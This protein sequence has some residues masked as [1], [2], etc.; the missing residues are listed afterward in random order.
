MPDES[1]RRTRYFNVRYNPSVIGRS[2]GSFL[3]WLATLVAVAVIGVGASPVR[4]QGRGEVGGAETGAGEIDITAGSF[5]V[6]GICR[7]GEWIGLQVITSDRAPAPRQVLIQVRVPDIDGDTAVYQRSVASN[8]GV[9]QGAWIYFR[10]PMSFGSGDAVRV[11]VNEAEDSASGFRAGRLLGQ[12]VVQARNVLKPYEGLIGIIGGKSVGLDQYTVRPQGQFHSYTPGGHEATEVSPSIPPENLCDRW[13]GLMQFDAL[14]WSGD[15]PTKLDTDRAAA[16]KEWVRRG[17]HLIIVLPPVGQTW[18]GDESYNPLADILP[19]VRTN[20]LEGVNLEDYRALLAADG[21]TPRPLPRSA[22]VHEFTP[23]PGAG[24]TEAMAIFGN[25][26]GK[27]NPRGSVVVR[28]LEGTGAVTL[29]GIDLSNSGLQLHGR[30]QADLFWHRILGRRGQLYSVQEVNDPKFG[31]VDRGNRDQAI[32]DRV[33]AKMINLDASAS[34]G[35]LLGFVVF[36]TYWLVAAPVSYGVLRRWGLTRHSWVAY[37]AAAGLFTAIAWGGV[38]LIK[39]TRVSGSH[40]TLLDYDH[41]S[42]KSRTRTWATLLIP[43][44]GTATVSVGE[45]GEGRG[46]FQNL[47]APWDSSASGDETAS[48]PDARPYVVE[49]RSPDSLTFPTRATVKQLQFDWA[50]GA[51]VGGGGMIRPVASEADPSAP[52]KITLMPPREGQLTPVLD[53]FLVHGL[54]LPLRNVSIWIVRGQK[55]LSA[56]SPRNMVCQSEVWQLDKA[57][58]P[59]VALDLATIT[60][61]KQNLSEVTSGERFVDGL[62]I[63]SF[64]GAAMD[65]ISPSDRAK[66]LRALGFISQFPPP[67][68]PRV[69][70]Q[71]ASAERQ[72]SHGWDLGRWFTQPCVIVVAQLG[73][74]SAGGEKAPCPTPIFVDGIPAPL[75]GITVIRWM[76]PLAADPPSYR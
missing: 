57:W 61:P 55:P 56:N 9:R 29:V 40:V 26:P 47:V 75:E 16:L 33:I 72:T 37:T 42:E 25:P 62:V 71:S 17:G 36:I 28:R 18:V 35:V 45:P 2:G 60:R 58:E 63:S 14:V 49:A 54:K 59:G 39:P 46:E 5:G 52:G 21:S 67:D 20:R 7:S 48:F 64:G 70:N 73:D 8:P 27:G 13:M 50:G 24:P 38:S 74:A 43:W 69:G 11:M 23:I 31:D 41:S 10:L 76:Y 44:Y 3:G 19:R 51:S 1:T 66:A 65:A 12:G 22:V 53:G 68:S 30:P 15:L 6:G 32:Y 4:G 34:K